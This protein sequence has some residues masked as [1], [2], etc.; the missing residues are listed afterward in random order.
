MDHC[1]KTIK[2]VVMNFT[3]ISLTVPVNRS[4]TKMANKHTLFPSAARELTKATKT[5]N[6]SSAVG[7]GHL[8]SNRHQ[9]HRAPA[10]Y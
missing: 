9:S 5:N 8:Y 10:A 2:F 7:A 4:C 6:R 1:Y 3:V